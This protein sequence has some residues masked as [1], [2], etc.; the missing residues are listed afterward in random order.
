[1][2][3]RLDDHV[4]VPLLS[5]DY[6][7]QRPDR[8]QEVGSD[9]IEEKTKYS[10]SHIPEREEGEDFKMVCYYLPVNGLYNIDDEEHEAPHHLDRLLHQPGEEEPLRALG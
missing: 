3:D 10:R 9:Q 6:N 5:L 1:M 2:R 7:V 4:R 8:E